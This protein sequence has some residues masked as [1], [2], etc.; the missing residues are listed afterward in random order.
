[1][2]AANLETFRWA[3]EMF[4]NITDQG[5]VVYA[6]DGIVYA[7]ED[8][9]T[10]MEAITVNLFVVGSRVGSSRVLA[11]CVSVAKSND[12]AGSKTL[13]SSVDRG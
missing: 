13:I 2:G 5:D 3:Q 9:E 10:L 6:L 12:T 4:P 7:L 1:M 8:P 11:A